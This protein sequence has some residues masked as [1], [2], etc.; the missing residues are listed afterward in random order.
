MENQGNIIHEL[1]F[2]SSFGLFL[3][4]QGVVVVA[5]L[6]VVNVVP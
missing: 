5:K 2:S 1:R 6:I 4:V 3:L